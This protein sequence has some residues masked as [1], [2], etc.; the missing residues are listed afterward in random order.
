MEIKKNNIF[1][2]I[3]NELNQKVLIYNNKYHGNKK[4]KYIY[5]LYK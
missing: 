3:I 4:K 5:I 1:I 2:Y